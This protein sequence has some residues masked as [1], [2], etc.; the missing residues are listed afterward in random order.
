M[1]VLSCVLLIFMK[2]KIDVSYNNEICGLSAKF[3]VYDIL[4]YKF[5]SL[6][7]GDKMH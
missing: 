5:T 4:Q 1:I 3:D 7:V 2:T 6:F